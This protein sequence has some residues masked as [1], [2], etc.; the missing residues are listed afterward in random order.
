MTTVT[1]CI[2]F[3]D[4]HIEQSATAIAS[5]RVQTEPRTVLYAQDVD[6]R[7]TG[8][9]RNQLLARV[10]T[11]FVV[12]LDA[13]DWI[14]PAF[15]ERCLSAYQAGKYVYTDWKEEETV[16]TAPDKCWCDGNWHVV[17]A[18]LRTEDVRS[19]GGFPED[20]PA[21]E[22]TA[23]YWQLVRRGICGVRLAEP[24]FHYGR[25]VHSR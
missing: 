23:M 21:A 25:G 7:G 6:R 4:Y 11:E 8:Y 16:K 1:I 18:L 9:M 15:V 2:P 17:T 3:A 5:A 24:L 22:D 20:L 10:Q 14:E 12:F 19:V 13:D